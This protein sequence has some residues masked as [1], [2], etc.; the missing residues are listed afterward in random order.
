MKVTTDERMPE[1]LSSS[2]GQVG[3]IEQKTPNT[4]LM[5]SRCNGNFWKNFKDKNA[6]E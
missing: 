6:Q 3:V 5:K 2:L 1:S 4:R